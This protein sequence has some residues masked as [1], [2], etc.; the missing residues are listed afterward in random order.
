MP[1][2]K[3]APPKRYT[4][5]TLVKKLESEGIGR[6]ATYAAIMENIV[7]RGYVK[8]EK[9]FLSPTSTGELIVDCLSGKFEFLDLGFTKDVE[10]D[11]D[12]IAQGEA[13]YKA[14]I[15]KVYEQLRNELSTLQLSVT[16]KHSCPECGKAL[17]RIKG[18][19][20]FFWGCSGYPDCSV[21]LP[22]ANGEPGQRKSQEVSEYA[23]K[24]CGKPLVHRFKKGKAGYDFWGCS[25]FKDG[26]KSSY[27]NKNGAPEYP[28]V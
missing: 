11:L 1:E 23:C 20:G 14:V 18:K 22:D 10:E 16:P 7:S 19:S 5:A 3:T 28:A 26:C 25:G 17:R 6:P 13:A 15:S 9:K 24:A 4:E 27:K 12:R 21:S 8:T 2:K